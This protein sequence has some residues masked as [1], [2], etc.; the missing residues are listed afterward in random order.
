MPAPVARHRPALRDYGR[1]RLTLPHQQ[2]R[3][4]Y[5]VGNLKKISIFLGEHVFQKVLQSRIEFELVDKEAL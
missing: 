1:G 3:S 4:G 5:L 2:A